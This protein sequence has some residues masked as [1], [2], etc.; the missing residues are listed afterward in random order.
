MSP[1]AID[2]VQ[3]TQA[4]PGDTLVVEI[5]GRATHFQQASS[6][7]GRAK[8]VQG[9]SQITATSAW[10]ASAILMQ[11]HFIIPTDAAL[12][13]W[14]VVAGDGYD[15]DLTLTEGFR[16]H[17]DPTLVSISPVGARQEEDLWITFTGRFTNFDQNG[18]TAFLCNAT[19]TIFAGPVAVTS[20]TQLSAFFSIPEGTSVGLW[21]AGVR[22][23]GYP[24]IVLN[25]AFAL[26]GS[27]PEISISISSLSDSLSSSEIA[28]HSL[29]VS[30][31]GGDKL[32]FRARVT[33]NL[34]L[35]KLAEQC[36]AG[37]TLTEQKSANGE[38]LLTFSP[39]DLEEFKANLER[40][41]EAVD[42]SLEYRNFKRIAV[43]GDNNYDMIYR[44][45][46]DSTLVER[47]LFFLVNDYTDYSALQSYD[48]LVV[49]ESYGGYVTLNEA[50]AIRRFYDHSKP[51]I[52]GLHYLE[53]ASQNIRSVLYP[54][55]GISSA[56]NSYSYYVYPNVNNPIADGV[57]PFSSNNGFSS[58]FVL[59][60]ADWILRNDYS[61]YLAVSFEGK[62]RTALFGTYLSDLSYSN[63]LLVAN[64]VNWMIYGK[65]WLK[66]SPD[67]TE[68]LPGASRIVDVILNAADLYTGDYSADINFNSDDPVHSVVTIPVSLHVIGVPNLFVVADS[69]SFDTVLVGSTSEDTAFIYNDGTGVLTITE[70]SS[71]NADFQPGITSA[72]VL[73]RDS[74]AL[75]LSFTPLAS[76]AAIGSLT[77]TSNDPDHPTLVVR[78]TGSGQLP[79]QISVAPASL[80]DTLYTG[81]I[82]SAIVTISNSGVADLIW[83]AVVEV[84]DSSM[85]VSQSPSF[86]SPN[87][88]SPDKALSDVL[89]QSAPDSLYVSPPLLARQVSNNESQNDE[90]LEKTLLN[91]NQSYQSVAA[92]IPNRYDFSEGVSGYYINDGG[93]DM[94]DG[95]NYL[96]TD[97]NLMSNISYSDNSICLS[98]ALGTGGRYFTR[99]VPGLFVFVAD[100]SGIQ[101]FTISGYVGANGSGNADGAVLQTHIA[102]LDF[103][104][105]VKRVY[106]A[107][108]P[109]VN[110]L[111]IV[112]YDPS[113]SHTFE[114]NT[115]YDFQQLSNLGGV[116]RIYDLLYASQNGGYVDNAATLRIM[117]AFLHAVGV[118]P[119]WVEVSPDSGVVAAGAQ[120]DVSVHFNAADLSGADYLADL[121]ISSNDPSAPQLHVPLTLT[122]IGAPDIRLS[123]SLLA[124][125]TVFVGGNLSRNLVVYNDGTA[126][127]AITGITSSSPEF[128]ADRDTLILA[129]DDSQLVHISFAP[130]AVGL[131]VETLTLASN[132]PDQPQLPVSLSGIAVAPPSISVVPDSLADTLRTN[133]F[134]KQV[135][136]VTNSGAYRLDFSV[137]VKYHEDLQT[138]VS[139]CIEGVSLTEV[140]S[141]DG[142]S[143]A[144][145]SPKDSVEFD[146]RLSGFYESVGRM[147]S[148]QDVPVVAVVG[149]QADEIVF[150]LMSDS[151]L[152]KDYLFY[153]VYNYSSYSLLKSYDG[154]IVAEYAYYYW[155]IEK[156]TVIRSFFDARKPVLLAADDFNSY[157]DSV[158]QLLNPVFGISSV[159]H[160]E[161]TWGS[162]NAAN[163]IT[164]GVT[165]VTMPY[166]YGYYCWFTLAKGDWIFS[167]QT[168]RH[169]GVSNDQA[170]R[171]VLF[172][173]DFSPFWD[174]DNKQLLRNAINWMMRFG[175]IALSPWNGSVAPGSSVDIDV[176]LQA[177]QMPEG[178]HQADVIFCSNDPAD[179]L[180]TIPAWL[181][182]IGIPDIATSDS[183]IDF[184]TV[185]VASTT[186]ESLLVLNRGTAALSVTN[187][188]A[189][190]PSFEIS[191]TSFT[192]APG[193]SQLVVLSLTPTSSGV[194]CD[195]LVIVSNDPDHPSLRVP[196]LAK[197]VTPPDISWT[198]SS[199]SDSL[200]TA[201][202][203]V[204]VFVLS[205]SGGSNL[206]YHIQFQYPL[207]GS[208]SSVYVE[209]VESEADAELSELGTVA[210]SGEVQSASPQSEPTNSPGYQP[211]SSTS[212]GEI[213]KIAV[214][215]GYSSDA[216]YWL[217][218]DSYLTARY[219]F[220]DLGNDVSYMSLNNY[221][222][223]IVS[224]YG[225]GITASEAT[226][227]AKFFSSHR[228][229]L[230]GMQDLYNGPS[231]AKATLFP[232][233]GIESV[234]YGYY[235]WGSL[236]LRHPISLGVNQV[237]QSF[238]Y[239]SWFTS[240][241]AQWIF[242]GQDSHFYGI[243]FEGSTRSVTIGA[244]LGDFLYYGSNQ[245]L[246]ANA[247]DWMMGNLGWMSAQPDTGTIA[248]GHSGNINLTLRG[249]MATPGDHIATVNVFSND[250]D[251]SL[252]TAPVYL[253]VTGEPD[254]ACSDTL[255]EFP[256]TY[257]GGRAY[258]TVVVVNI[259]TTTLH[260][261]A[262]VTDSSEFGLD[263]SSFSVGPQA[264]R[265]LRVAYTP[266]A[267]G[268]TSGLLELHSDD[269]DHP[270]LTVHLGGV[271]KLPP[272][273]E[274][275]P[276]ILNVTL[277]VDDTTTRII[278]IVNQGTSDLMYQVSVSSLF[279]SQFA[280][281]HSVDDSAVVPA[282]KPPVLSGVATGSALG[283]RDAV[284]FHDDFEGDTNGWT[285][286]SS[287]GCDLW[288]VTTRDYNS[289]T[290]SWWCGIEQQGNYECAPFVDAALISPAISL[291]GWSGEIYLIFGESYNTEYYYDNCMVDISTNGGVSWAPLRGRYG[292]SVYGNSYGWRSYYLDISGFAG[293]T[294]NIRF[295]FD[296][297]DEYNNDYPG[298]F[299]DDVYIVAPDI[300]PISL[301]P[302]QG[303]VSPNDTSYITAEF[304]ASLLAPGNYEACIMVSSNDPDES[305]VDIL[306]HLQI[307]TPFVCG[308][309]DGDGQITVADVVFLVSYLF[310]L[311]NPPEPLALGDL[312]CD[313]SVNIADPVYLIN[314]IFR[315]GPAPCSVR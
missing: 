214:V 68:V 298:W 167:D 95:G 69:I 124:F 147:K 233:L 242:A 191:A 41:H 100:V 114:T 35:R 74:I 239:G 45:M 283:L 184:G 92:I 287:S 280:L 219:S 44:L 78:L 281:A 27:P 60:G 227:I 267:V 8:L 108:D 65:G 258:D 17:A 166:Y 254:I 246:M 64:A 160:T 309:A 21:N 253:R 3:P 4:S 161:F 94:Y 18:P 307:E 13:L 231:D 43:V 36:V 122:V 110:H 257:V 170:A 165:A 291:V 289:A 23:S 150:R 59:S 312:N 302:T 152:A 77:I 221:Q 235:A 103:L 268:S 234:A 131:K 146:S 61:A 273:M 256:P 271:G 37:V 247:I 34:E 5:T 215:G 252:I 225:S 48:A 66:V 163:P 106:N 88:Q 89:K 25:G 310:Q 46:S 145:L 57:A 119:D 52:M 217:S 53:D 202:S 51:I 181:H 15:P 178:D 192:L 153:R 137:D 85:V 138:L 315:G 2:H 75:P 218:R 220:T 62:T 293:T 264:Q 83:K 123:A 236:N 265:G 270:M 29:S 84:V 127:L 204:K 26:A 116:T 232:I 294:I 39:T 118:G 295:R 120:S 142:Q 198:P 132:D 299:V 259:G 301:T 126:D 56:S 117:D 1:P 186:A 102:G 290:H 212:N 292:N 168:G 243:S 28:T 81:E 278:S 277:G 10:V 206:T 261:T 55:F 175:W 105:F 32:H 180:L 282:D 129:P 172:G 230:V 148:V 67:S 211:S 115:N 70:I 262:I 149:D 20:S 269:P 98:S 6:S 71:D 279:Q 11:A 134:S 96:S 300:T 244:Y 288:H 141:A 143:V 159:G 54:V 194:L 101:S 306:V 7:I 111:I 199:F 58:S 213:V 128:S 286:Q 275:Y 193:D 136:T 229:V 162:L 12:G 183:V 216:Y 93:N 297:R 135:L 19:D 139:Q 314:Y 182:V 304:D 266:K 33:Y 303:T 38:S 224:E 155:S 260:V 313:G 109:S 16:I 90:S 285:H 171:S 73:P 169:Y 255:I 185:F 63:P 121:A 125:D 144:T 263:T 284:I 164:E 189:T 311:G 176:T 177:R 188:S 274:L 249:T 47:Y 238:Y 50:E 72:T 187:L 30:N 245:K 203:V 99:K 86:G 272:D 22:Q 250:P 223:L 173:A 42:K 276:S 9:A 248:S 195:T 130:Q 296:T 201:D 179:S 205:N 190:S 228:P 240:A 40:Y 308:D 210:E 207:A 31:F 107:G 24:D 197:V 140:M 14:D 158:K 87:R 251:H 80:Q 157:P 305:Y 237:S 200:S 112:K 208:S 76:G 113:V 174:V 222:G 154:L 97:P 82:S 209:T 226:T 49:A 241:G 156:A 104:G 196:I 79:P 151:I 91:L 133:E